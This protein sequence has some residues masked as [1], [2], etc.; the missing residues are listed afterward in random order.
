MRPE[1]MSK[2]WI[3]AG[4]LPFAAFLAGVPAGGP[5]LLA[6][7]SAGADFVDV[8]VATVG[9]E[10]STGAPLALLRTGWDEVLPV[11][12]GETEA[13]AI[14]R[15]L[16]GVTVPR[17]MTHDLLASVM[18]RLGGTL[19]E[20]VV[21]EL[22]GETFIGLLRIRTSG[23]VEEVDTRP[24]DALALAVRTGARVRVARILLADLPDLDFMSLEGTRSV[25][26][27]RG[28]TVG[29][30]ESDGVEVLHVAPEFAGRG[31]QPGDLVVAVE[32][33]PV[34]SPA[35]FVRALGGRTATQ[36]LE[37]ERE[38]D[39]RRES[40]RLPPRSGPPVVGPQ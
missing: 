13:Q 34:G 31:L 6:A 10:L 11:W 4:F 20:V 30:S 19:E 7:Q 8:E 38:R 17:P 35:G 2:P 40:V 39:G 33:S 24:S 36:A 1:R 28:I 32:G 37:V 16:A 29:E 18:T 3:A 9:V 12:I 23:G 22:R 14:A 25:A 27:I 21:T 26:R 15:V 5:T